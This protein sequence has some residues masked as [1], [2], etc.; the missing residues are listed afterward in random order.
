MNK[1]KTQVKGWKGP[2]V[3]EGVGEQ[4][5]VLNQCWAY[6]KDDMGRWRHRDIR[7]ESFQG[8]GSEGAKVLRWEQA[9]WV[10][11]VWMEWKWVVQRGMGWTMGS[12]IRMPWVVL[13]SLLLLWDGKLLKVLNRGMTWY[14]LYSNRSTLLRP[15]VEIGSMGRKPFQQW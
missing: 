4:T 15:K 10:K 2:R 9:C 14:D 7:G 6:W 13:S 1:I 3:P 11:P 12:I 8:I 5:V